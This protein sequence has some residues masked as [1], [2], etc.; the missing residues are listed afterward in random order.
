MRRQILW[1]VAV[2]A[3]A[4]A[5]LV[6]AGGAS[7]TGMTQVD[8]IQTLVGG[9]NTLDPTDDV[10]SMDGYGGGRPALVGHWYTRSFVVGVVTPSGV[11]T[12]T[13]SEEFVGC[14]DANGNRTC[15]G[16]EPAG[17]IGLAY[18]F[19]GKFDLATGGEDHGRCHHAITD[20]TEGFA[21][22]TGVLRFKDDPEAGCAFYSGHVSLG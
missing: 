13:G 5:A 16:D 1:L 10:F 20:G 4:A 17:T 2:V 3:I 8:G 6:A 15:D 11:L 22:V 14:L 19:S 12:S 18:E 21:G 9:G 7:A